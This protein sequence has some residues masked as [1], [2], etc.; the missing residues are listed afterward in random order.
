[1]TNEHRVVSVLNRSTSADL[2]VTVGSSSDDPTAPAHDDDGGGAV[3]YVI[4]A[5]SRRTIENVVAGPTR[6]KLKS[7]PAVVYEIEA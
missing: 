4:P 3:G 5:G 7:V 2:F 6:V 1:M